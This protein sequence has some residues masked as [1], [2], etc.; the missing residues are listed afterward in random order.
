MTA[1]DRPVEPRV[2]TET[3]VAEV[4]REVLHDETVDAD[5]NFFDVGGDSVLAGRVVARL[6]VRTGARVSLRAFFDA[7][8]P[9]G[10]AAVIDSNLA[11]A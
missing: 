6:R 10:V 3:I 8:T 4:F 5:T 11:S 7:P 2:S 9:P 1:T